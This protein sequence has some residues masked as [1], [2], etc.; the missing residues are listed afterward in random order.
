MSPQGNRMSRAGMCKSQPG[1]YNSPLL[2]RMSRPGTRRSPQGT[3][4]SPLRLCKSPAGTCKSQ[5]FLCKSPVLFRKSPRGSCKSR[6]GNRA[7]PVIWRGSL[8]EARPSHEM[9][10]SRTAL[11][12]AASQKAGIPAVP[13]GGFR[14]LPAFSD[15]SA[16]FISEPAVRILCASRSRTKRDCH[17]PGRPGIACSD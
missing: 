15:L 13:V 17:R 6:L 2:F 11:A 14:N 12:C 4:K 9:I 10:P 3:Y 5:V 1:I 8:A 16:V 7:S